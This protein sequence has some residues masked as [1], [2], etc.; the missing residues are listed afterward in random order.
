MSLRLF[1]WYKIFGEGGALLGIRMPI[2]VMMG[3]S[4][5]AAHIPNIKRIYAGTE[6]KITFPWEK[7]KGEKKDKKEKNRKD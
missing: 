7:K 2:A 6:P 3:I 4:V 5:I 1:E